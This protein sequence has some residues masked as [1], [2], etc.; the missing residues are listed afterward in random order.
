MEDIICI[1][2]L[3]GIVYTNWDKVLTMHTRDVTDN[4]RE[5]DV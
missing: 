3:T 4:T 2:F 5:P 1:S